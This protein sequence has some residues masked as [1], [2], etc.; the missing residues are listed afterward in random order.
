MFELDEILAR[1][2]LVLGSFPLCLLLASRDGNYP[3]YILVPR[4]ADVRE[5]FELSVV[6]QRQ[7]LHESVVLS[8]A[9]REAHG[10]D[11]LNVAALGNMVPQLHIHHIV[12]YK[13]DP[14]W[15]KPVWGTVPAQIL[16][17]DVLRA[18]AE[19]LLK[20][21]STDFERA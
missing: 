13:E 11:K 7:L 16:A 1:D 15:P 17:E 4:R 20:S 12:R 6:D 19:S 18:R 3:W 14:A 9:L 8:R 10:G 2:S 5:V 21:L